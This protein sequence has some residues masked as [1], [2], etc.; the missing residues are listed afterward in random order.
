MHILLITTLDSAEIGRLREE[1]EKLGHQVTVTHLGNFSFNVVNENLEIPGI[2][3]VNPD[4]V[5]L[6]GITRNKA[7]IVAMVRHYRNQGIPVFDN[8]FANHQYS[9]NKVTDL[10]KL[11]QAGV[12]IPNTF[13]TTEFDK[14]YEAADKFGYPV[15]IKLIGTGKGAGI[16]KAEN[17]ENIDEIVE[18]ANEMEKGA[19]RFIIQKFIPYKHDLRV[20]IIG[21]AIYVMK[22]IPGEGEFRAN[23]SL[24]G[25]VELFD[26]DQDGVDLARRAIKAVDMT[27]AG[28]DLLL[29][30]DKRYVLEV[31]HTPGF[32]GM[33]K[34]TNQNIGKIYL[35]HAIAA[36]H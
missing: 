3:E 18:K 1:G 10:I 16:F 32:L 29:T 31:N 30:D 4:M 33:E 19:N 15:V 5:I 23:F 9:I 14:W 13:H 25:S 17:P 2:T 27:I 26:L 20:L 22:R 34:A 35:E 7:P 36:A 28:V 12:P 6:K 24:G 21:D 11:S 8:N